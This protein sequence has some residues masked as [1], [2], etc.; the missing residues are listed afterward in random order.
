MLRTF[1]LVLLALLVGAVSAAA[2]GGPSGK[3]VQA[4]VQRG[5][6]WLR[7]RHAQG[8]ET[9]RKHSVPELVA[10]TLNHA[11][12]SRKDKVFQAALEAILGCELEHT[13]R[14]A[15]LA[16]TLS[17]LN[18]YVYRAKLAHCAQWLVDTQLPGG[19]W[20]YPGNVRGRTQATRALKVKPPVTEEEAKG[21]PKAPVIQIQ[22]RTDPAK[23][24]GEHGD[25][26]NTQFALLGLRACLDARI[27]IPKE[28]WEAALRYMVDQQLKD[29]SWGYPHAGERDEGG[30]ASATSAG[31][32]GCAICLK[33]LKKSVRSHAAVKKA[34]AW[35]KKNWTPSENA[36]IEDST[37][38]LPSYWQCYQLYAVE[39][40]GRILGFK[41]LGKRD[42][43][44][45]GARWLLDS[46]R[47]D[48]S[49][50][51][52]GVDTTARRPPYMD[53]ADTCFAILF[54]TLATPPLT[55]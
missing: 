24:E 55:G 6:D 7:K 43:Y 2:K 54:L 31:L 33:Y 42:W 11:G 45:E 8:F 32:A 47:T 5:A 27:V 39:R 34:L 35:L 12:V 16:M 3:E 19:D 23:F 29:G 37:F 15:T 51:D 28:T 41:K 44:K 25:F 36:G 21:G 1:A 26:S 46:Q 22:R 13:Y 52:Q 50:R 49:W 17:R 40:A 4:A 38:I 10:L 53:T 20:G 30:Y 9:D 18:P 14:V 48:G